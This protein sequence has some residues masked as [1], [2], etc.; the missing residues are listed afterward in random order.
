MGGEGGYAPPPRLQNFRKSSNNKKS[1]E[2]WEGGTPAHPHHPT[3]R[4]NFREKVKIKFKKRNGGGQP[5]P[6]PPPPCPPPTPLV[7]VP[8]LDSLLESSIESL[9]DI[10]NKIAT[11]TAVIL[12]LA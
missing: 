12:F 1:K 7:R 4:Q 3:G 11:K 2:N 5:T 10:I 8:I 9:Y 6:N